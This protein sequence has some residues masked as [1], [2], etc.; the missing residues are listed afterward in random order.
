MTRPFHGQ[1][2]TPGR[3]AKLPELVRCP[4]GSWWIESQKAPRSEFYKEAAVH[5]PNMRKRGISPDRTDGK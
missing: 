2:L 1:L 3:P 4:D 5:Q